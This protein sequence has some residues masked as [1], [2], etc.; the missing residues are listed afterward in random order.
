[1]TSMS[2]RA[3]HRVQALTNHLQCT[4]SLSSSEAFD[5]SSQQFADFLVVTPEVKEALSSGRPVVA[6][7]STIISHGM[8]YPQNYQTAREVEQVARDNG[9]VP[10]TIAILDGKLRVGL[11]DASLKRLAILGHKARKCSRRDLAVVMAEKGDGATTVA[12]TMYIAH[13][14]GIRV[15]VTGGIGGVHRGVEETMD[16]SADLTEFGRTPVAVVC[17]GAKS[18]LDI[19]RTLEYLETQ[20]VSVVGYGV[21]ELPAF[22]TRSSGSDAPLRLDTAEQ[23]AKLLQANRQLELRSGVVIAVPIPHAEEAEAALIVKATEA[24]LTELGP[25]GIKGKDVTPY[26]LQRVN[27]LTDGHSLTSNIALVKNNCKVGSQIAVSLALL[28]KT[29]S[30]SSTTRS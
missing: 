3:M 19:P 22:F 7:E 17:A 28:S 6:L 26:L 21:S 29:S 5:V 4:Q 2:G 10:A 12:A 8:P 11:D 27:E 1:M 13:L 16:I 20:G 15:F 14:A 9:A 25:K 24:A 23:C 18:I 30:T